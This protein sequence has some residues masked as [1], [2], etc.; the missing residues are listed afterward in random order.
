MKMTQNGYFEKKIDWDLGG[1]VGDYILSP[2]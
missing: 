2:P 1:E